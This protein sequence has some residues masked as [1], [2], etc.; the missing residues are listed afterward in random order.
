MSN[1]ISNSCFDLVNENSRKVGSIADYD[2]INDN[3]G[4]IASGFRIDPSGAYFGGMK[5]FIIFS[6]NSMFLVISSID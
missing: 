6:I 5:L 3:Y 2:P 1:L 4:S